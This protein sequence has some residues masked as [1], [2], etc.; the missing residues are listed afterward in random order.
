MSLIMRL[1]RKALT[2]ASLRWQMVASTVLVSI[3][4]VELASGYLA[5]IPF[6]GQQARRLW[7]VAMKGYRHTVY[8]GRYRLNLKFEQ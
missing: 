1:W 2:P 8:G 4:L 7:R 3:Y 5:R 6:I